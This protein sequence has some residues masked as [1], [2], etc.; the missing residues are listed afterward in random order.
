MCDENADRV[1]IPVLSARLLTYSTPRRC[2][3]TMRGTVATLLVLLALG[4]LASGGERVSPSSEPTIVRGELSEFHIPL[5]TDQRVC[6][7][8]IYSSGAHGVDC[9]E[10]SWRLTNP[11]PSH[12]VASIDET[13]M[14]AALA[15]GKAT[16]SVTYLG[17]TL[18]T[19]CIVAAPE[20]K[21]LQLGQCYPT[22]DAGSK[23]S[24]RV[25]AELERGAWKEVMRGVR[26][27]VA[28]VAPA[29]Q[30]AVIDQAGQVTGLH[31]G[32]AE[33]QATWMG[34]T[35][36]TI[37]SVVSSS[38]A[39]PAPARIPGL[40]PKTWRHLCMARLR[41]VWLPRLRALPKAAVAVRNIGDRHYGVITVAVRQGAL[42]REISIH[43]DP[44]ECDAGAPN[45]GWTP[46]GFDWRSPS[47]QLEIILSAAGYDCLDY[48]P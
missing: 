29:R 12:P 33:I 48:I 26:W 9:R 37:L 2:R 41:H 22:I 24:F 1:N 45:S 5:G 40:R 46:T 18:S 7:D 23:E 42:E 35:A 25:T 31:P 19:Q 11:D 15:V 13:G 10:R 36:S 14:V 34:Q 4:S 28:D 39:A 3:V 30:V 17:R 20:V 21:K 43:W 16:L 38:K 27:T 6:I 47:T 8:A 32:M 44:E